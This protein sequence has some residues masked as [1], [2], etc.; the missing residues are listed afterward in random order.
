MIS[1]FIALSL[2]LIMMLA[3]SLAHFYTSTPISELRR[4]AHNG[5]RAASALHEISRNV[6]VAKIYLHATAL[7]TFAVLVVYISQRMSM[8]WGVVSILAL[9]GLVAATRR[10]S[11]YARLLATIFAPYFGRFIVATKPYMVYGAKLFRRFITKKHRTQIYELDDLIEMIKLQNIAT[12]N[13]I[14]KT[15]LNRV[16]NTLT[17]GDKLVGDYLTPRGAVRFVRSDELV[18]TVLMNELHESGFSCFPVYLDNID[19]VIGTLYLKDLVEK[20][21]SGKVFSAMSNEVVD[22]TETETLEAVLKA[23]LK[24]QHYLF[25]V[26]GSASE[27]V[28]IITIEDVLKQIF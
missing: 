12:N 19:D 17:F 1:L 23:F 6:C 7:V 3:S 8:F 21:L 10:Y 5:D 16:L 11:A 25:V 22:V 20:R 13:R 24:T 9:I 15:D 14:E 26:R 18:S 2:L 28:G 4:R 27:V